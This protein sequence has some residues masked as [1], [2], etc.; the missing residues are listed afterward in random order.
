[1][2]IKNIIFTLL[3]L[4]AGSVYADNSSE[5]GIGKDYRALMLPSDASDEAFGPVQAEG[6]QEGVGD[7]F[8]NE[9]T[10]NPYESESPLIPTDPYGSPS[11]DNTGRE[12]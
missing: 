3:I 12:Y 10:N 8:G 7:S 9:L 2:N 1:M 11:L 4:F 5:S 6:F